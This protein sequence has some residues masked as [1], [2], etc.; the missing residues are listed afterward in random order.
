MHALPSGHAQARQ[1]APPDALRHLQ[2]LDWLGRC[3]TPAALF[4]MGLW[5]PSQWTV[6]WSAGAAG[7][8]RAASATDLGKRSGPPATHLDGLLHWLKV[9]C[10]PTNTPM[11]C[12]VLY[13]YLHDRTVPWPCV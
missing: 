3:T 7:G 4:A 13:C 12:H 10:L 1:G 11:P 6:F 2:T 8:S 9:C 5:I